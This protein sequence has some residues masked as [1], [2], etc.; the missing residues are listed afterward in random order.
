MLFKRKL[1]TQPTSTST[2]GTS[3][4]TLTYELMASMSAHVCSG[5]KYKY[6]SFSL[7]TFKF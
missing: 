2:N 1:S 5:Y 3:T 7:D 4:I 6:A